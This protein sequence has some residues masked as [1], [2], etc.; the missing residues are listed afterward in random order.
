M[1]YALDMKLLPEEFLLA[2]HKGTVQFN[3]ESVVYNR[4]RMA[5]LL[6]QVSPFLDWLEGQED[7]EESEEEEEE[8]EETPSPEEAKSPEGPK[9]KTEAQLKQEALIAKQLAAQKEASEK[10]R[11]E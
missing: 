7:D 3:T 1:K 2:W 11:R 4:A 8:E 9:A 10:Q 6:E 5:T